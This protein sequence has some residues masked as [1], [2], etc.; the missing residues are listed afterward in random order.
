MAYC[1]E[2]NESPKQFRVLYNQLAHKQHI[3]P[4]QLFSSLKLNLH[5]YYI[6]EVFNYDVGISRLFDEMASLD[7]PSQLKFVGLLSHNPALLIKD[8]GLEESFNK[9]LKH[10]LAVHDH[11]DD[12][13]DLMIDISIFIK[14][15]E[16][17]ISQEFLNQISELGQ[18]WGFEISLKN[19]QLQLSKF[20][21]LFKSSRLKKF[22]WL[23]YQ[24]LNYLVEDNFQEF[25]NGFIKLMNNSSVN[26]VF[27]EL[28][29]SSIECYNAALNDKDEIVTKNWNFFITNQI[30]L[31]L[32]NILK[33]NQ[34]NF[35][36]IL[37][38]TLPNL[39]H[40][41]TKLSLLKNLISFKLI[42]V[43]TFY[44]LIGESETSM[45]INELIK[46]QNESK[47][48]DFSVQDFITKNLIESNP[49]F[50]TLDN[51]D[52]LFHFMKNFN[53]INLESRAE[54][55]KVISNTI[56]K[57]SDDKDSTRLR[58]LLICIS[59]NLTVLD[60]IIFSTNPNLIL[61]KLTEV[62]CN[63][64]Y[65]ND[66]V[67]HND[68]DISMF[69][70]DD[71]ENYQEL[72]TDYSVILLHILF[73]SRRYHLNIPNV[74]NL[75]ILK[76]L[77]NFQKS[78][79]CSTE[80]EPT[81]FNE[82]YD[83]IYNDTENLISDELISKTSLVNSF[84]IIPIVFN[85][86][87]L[88]Y[89]EGKITIDL[90]LNGFDF[91][92]QPFLIINLISIFYRL[93]DFIWFDPQSELI[94]SILNKILN[95]KLDGESKLMFDLIWRHCSQD[96]AHWH[97]IKYDNADFTSVIQKVDKTEKKPQ[98]YE[99]IF[100]Q[101]LNGLINWNLKNFDLSIY[102]QLD[103]INY[104]QI[105][106]L[107]ESEFNEIAGSSTETLNDDKNLSV[108]NS[109]EISSFL[110]LVLFRFDK[111]VLAKLQ[112]L[113]SRPLQDGTPIL[114]DL[115]YFKT[116]SEDEFHTNLFNKVTLKLIQNLTNL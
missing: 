8:P 15:H 16:I 12:F 20:I 55:A 40:H 39:I 58:R 86:S 31:I 78:K 73:I 9:Y 82:W 105:F 53:L 46:F 70:D 29:S 63:S 65:L 99:T 49:E 66:K 43:E 11:N 25:I 17:S 44:H 62:C 51:D 5:Y 87:I 89:Q 14:N 59:S 94:W 108:V 10:L 116:A 57:L 4:R 85:N 111:A 112:E 56:A 76:F 106:Q 93:D 103:N 13:Q 21:N 102:F 98:S 84:E 96:F 3:E 68:E 74:N 50:T 33:L 81:F 110:L 69:G 101:N 67:S 47:S 95:L 88:S 97:E 35:E 75:F 80:L 23:Q 27:T 54:F 100:I 91:F 60:L 113:L 36:I 52:K 114:K 107:M 19:D 30:P 109:L 45:E 26:F 48:R 2:N 28:L 34:E 37:E 22:I 71:I 6:L 41:E 104:Y 79:S 24:V 7:L 32:H 92:T 38:K 77:Q 72:Y 61:L 18:T 64:D 115:N 1:L 83:S 90:L 42:K